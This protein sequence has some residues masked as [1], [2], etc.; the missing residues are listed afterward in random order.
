MF[1]IG[2]PELIVLLLVALLIVGPKRLPEVGK[3]IGRSLREF[4][5]AQDD[6]KSS[7]NF[8]VEDEAPAKTAP[9]SRAKE[10]PIPNPKRDDEPT[11]D[12][13]ADN[14]A[15]VEGSSDPPADPADED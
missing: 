3:T 1:N 12:G 9:K 11:V 7:F 10:P 2:P 14:P 15:A 4:R 5:K 6:L 13:T 8:D